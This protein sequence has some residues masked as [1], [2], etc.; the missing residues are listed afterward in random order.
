MPLIPALSRAALGG[1]ALLLA[2]LPAAAQS[3]LTLIDGWAT[4]ALTAEDVVVRTESTEAGI[5]LSLTNG[6][7]QL[8]RVMA[9][10][11]AADQVGRIGRFFDSIEAIEPGQA[12]DQA[13]W[14]LQG[15]T[16]RPPLGR[17]A[18]GTFAVRMMVPQ[19]CL[20]GGEAVAIAVITE[21][22]QEAAVD[23]LLAG[24]SLTRP[25]GA[26][27]CALDD[28]PATVTPAAGQPDAAVAAS[29][30][31]LESVPM[32]GDLVF[33]TMLD[34]ATVTG[35]EDENGATEVMV[36][37]GAGDLLRFAGAPLQAPLADTVAQLLHRVDGIESAD[38]G[39]QP[40]WLLSGPSRVTVFDDAAPVESE[41]PARVIV[42]M[43]CLNGQPAYVV[44]VVAEPGRDAG[45]VP[46]I[47]AAG[48]GSPPGAVP[49][50]DSIDTLL[51]PGS[52]AQIAAAPSQAVT[53]DHGKLPLA[54]A[55]P[56]PAP[57]LADAGVLAGM[58][59]EVGLWAEAVSQNRPQGFWTYLKA[60]PNGQFVPL[61]QVMLQGAVA[62]PAQPAAPAP[63]TK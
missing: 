44:G 9:A 51:T 29:D 53:G 35:F 63:A 1:L 56:E 15:T 62:M 4:L 40:V 55:M 6:Q 60:Y 43:D 10:V 27:D 30:E 18:D 58:S 26:Q 31:A 24:L 45:M 47:L 34:G 39:G 17:R 46:L 13:V 21:I 22:G 49:C 50:A 52:A 42:P 5:D 14:L 36:T 48:A 8:L 25:E 11:P 7:G 41:T 20:A 61:A 19:A 28:L 3:P 59:D 23:A 16:D 12:G 33:L 38:L 32:L 54:G 37:T 57:P 2:P